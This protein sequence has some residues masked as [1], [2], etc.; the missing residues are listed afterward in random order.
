[1]T[2][3]VWNPTWKVMTWEQ[4]QLCFI[5]DPLPSLESKPKFEKV[6]LNSSSSRCHQQTKKNK[7][8]LAEYIWTQAF[9]ALKLSWNLRAYESLLNQLMVPVNPLIIGEIVFLNNKV[10]HPLSSTQPTH[11]SSDK[12]YQIATWIR[13]IVLNQQTHS[14]THRSCIMSRMIEVLTSVWSESPDLNASSHTKTLWWCLMHTSLTKLRRI[15]RLFTL[16][17]EEVRE[18]HQ[19]HNKQ[20]DIKHYYRTKT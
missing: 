18:Q 6:M 14:S 1:M 2:A 5:S 17:R 16:R 3:W 9:L 4:T 20:R 15:L 7:Q 12:D 11:T 10:R 19:I 8:E 13:G